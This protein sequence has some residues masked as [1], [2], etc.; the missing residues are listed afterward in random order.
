MKIFINL[1]NKSID[2]QAGLK[3]FKKMKILKS[4]KFISKR[5]FLDIE[6]IYL[7]KKYSKKI[8]SIPA[9]Y[10]ISDKSSIN[11][12]SFK[13]NLEIFI[14]LIKVIINIILAKKQF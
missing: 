13:K 5:F 11:I 14:E 6:L 10:S 8:I 7:Y 1:E 2:T 4:Y 9:K 12:F 3:G